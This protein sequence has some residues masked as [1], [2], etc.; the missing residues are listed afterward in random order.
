MVCAYALEIAGARPGPLWTAASGLSIEQALDHAAE[1]GVISHVTRDK[2]TA[3]LTID[4]D[5]DSET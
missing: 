5:T 4:H 3:M 1:N 2:I